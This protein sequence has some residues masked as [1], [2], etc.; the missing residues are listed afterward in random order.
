MSAD[1]DTRREL[2]LVQLYMGD[3]KGKTT[4]ALG[5]A[6]RAAGRGLR[7][8]MIQFLKPAGDCGE[9]AMAERVDGITILPMGLDHM[10]GRAVT[11]EEDVRS[12]KAAL[13]KA[14]EVL[15]SGEY[16]IVILDE[17]NNAVRMGFLEAKDLIRV[18]DRRAKQVEVVLTGRCTS[19]DLVDYADLVTEMRLVKHPF[20]DGTG[21][22]AGIEY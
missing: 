12:A 18:L 2:G 4:A 6:F 1:D 13:A 16:D 3:G 14:D 11:R 17:A 22:R 5:L 10:S 7:V 21:A 15:R 9:Q 20:R 19:Q 8:V